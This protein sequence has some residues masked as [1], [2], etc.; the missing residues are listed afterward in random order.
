MRFVSTRNSALT[1]TAAE[2]IMKGLAPDG[3]LYIPDSI[4]HF[5]LTEI[6]NM[7]KLPYPELAARVI[8]PFL[9][10]FTEEELLE[11]CRKAYSSFGS[12][13]VAPIH[14]LD[15]DTHVLELFHG[16]TCAFKD[17]ALQLLPYLMSASVKKCGSSHTVAILV[18]TSGDTGKAALEGF[19]DVPGTKICVFYP[20]G[21]VSDIQ[22]LQMVTQKGDNVMVTAVKGNFD[23]AQSGV[24]AIFSDSALSKRLLEHNVVLSSANSINWGRLAPQIVYY[25]SA[26]LQL[27]NK[28]AIKPGEAVDFCVPTGNFGNILA[29]YF[30]KLSGLPVGK[31][32]CASNKNDV[33]TDFIRTG[34][35]DRNRPFHLTMSPSMDIL[36]S[37]NLERMLSLLSDPET[38]SHLMEQLKN[39]GCYTVSEDMLSKLKEAG[40]VGYCSDEEITSNTIRQIFDDYDYAADTHTAVGLSALMQ[41]REANADKNVSVVLST[42]SPFKFAGSMLKCLGQNVSANGFEQLD[43]LSRYIAQIPPSALA[44][45]RN[46][47][48]SF[49]GVIGRNDMADFVENW[50]T[51]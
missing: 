20:D 49:P 47:E 23:D 35:Y 12:P 21:G 44:D 18:A 32:I 3:G 34:I 22:R 33:L 17:F 40:F 43:S 5:S 14:T 19:S 50:L 28:N 39:S 27:L 46:A 41:H 38:V 36:I 2:A 24:K 42:A 7:K 45:L 29:G 8:L 11:Y 13:L 16:P 4:P 48:I 6:E 10:G 25:Y 30:A 9:P 15:N 31:L 51:E 1:A 37:S 26:Y